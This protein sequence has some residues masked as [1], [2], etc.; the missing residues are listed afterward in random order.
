M[1]E[2]QFALEEIEE[3]LKRAKYL[4]ENDETNQFAAIYEGDSTEIAYRDLTNITISILQRPELLQ[5]PLESLP[6]LVRTAKR[7]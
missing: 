5:V 2:K 6:S 1:G 7:E 4:L 3:A